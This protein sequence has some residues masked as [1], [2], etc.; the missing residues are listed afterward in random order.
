M[1]EFSDNVKHRLIGVGLYKVE[2]NPE[3][4]EILQCYF[5]GI[6]HISDSITY[7]DSKY[8]QIYTFTD[9]VFLQNIFCNMSRECC[10]YINIFGLYLACAYRDKYYKYISLTYPGITAYVD[11][12]KLEQFL[13]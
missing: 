2:D 13:L 5:D 3:L 9:D 7:E 12:H 1:S 10:P 4:L 6:W 8:T 11:K